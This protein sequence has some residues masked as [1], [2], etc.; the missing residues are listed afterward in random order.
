LAYA[1]SIATYTRLVEEFPSEG[2]THQVVIWTDIGEPLDRAAVNAAVHDL[3]ANV[4]QDPA[5]ELDE[6][7]T[8]D[9]SLDRY[10][11]TVDVPTGYDYS[12]PQAVAGL[13][14]LRDELVPASLGAVANTDTGVTGDTAWTADFKDLLA[15]RMPLVVGFVLVLTVAVFVL[16]F[17]SLTIAMTAVVL[18]LLSVAAAYGL[19]T[20]VFQHTWAESLLG[21]HSSGA[22]LTW[23]PL[24]L[25]VI[26]FGLSMD[27]H[28]FVVSRSAKQGSPVSRPGT[29]W[30]RGSRAPPEQ[31]P[32]PPS[33]W[34]RCSR[35]SRCCPRLTSNRWGSG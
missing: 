19:L 17:R 32:V 15:Q 6:P 1:Q 31:S 27:Y 8:A 10:V 24:F 4:V 25:F 18:N 20:L 33:S 3:S 9:Y 29:P 35:S 14:R 16:A 12:S 23:L 21:F 22:I 28:V 30:P 34:W 26:L 2:S 11:A 7:L 13:D 5:F